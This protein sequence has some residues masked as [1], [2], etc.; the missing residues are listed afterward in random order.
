MRRQL[1][2]L[3]RDETIAADDAAVDAV[4]LAAGGERPA[5]RA[6][7]TQIGE[8]ENARAAALADVSLGYKRGRQPPRP[9]KT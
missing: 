5:V 8:M 4:I 7:L 3:F 2:E 6:L 9:L 1:A